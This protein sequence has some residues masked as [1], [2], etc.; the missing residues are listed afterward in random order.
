MAAP[1]Q[2][3]WAL[4]PHTAAKHA[5]LSR[6]LAAWLPI[7]SQGGFPKLAYIDAFSGPGRYSG[8]EDGSPVIALK[9]MLGHK[10]SITAQCYFDFVERAADRAAALRSAVEQTQAELGK[11]S[12]AHIEVHQST[13]ESAYEKIGPRLR[14]SG[15]IPTFAFIDPFGWTGLPFSIV[16]ELLNRPSTEV[17][18]NF[19]FEEINRFL[20]H[21]DQTENFDQLFGCADWRDCINLSGPERNQAL[22]DLYARK[23]GEN[24]K[25]VRYFEMRNKSNATDY[26]LFF[27]TNSLQGLKKMKEAMWKVDQGGAFN[28]SDA[29]NPNQMTLFANE[30]QFDQLKRQIMGQ[31][32]GM[33][34][35]IEQVEEFVLTRTAFRE[36]HFKRQ[37]LAKVE[38]QDFEVAQSKPG[39]RRGT[40]PAGTLLKFFG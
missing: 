38:G 22:R 9:A 2:T 37:V 32:R 25:Y 39:R 26:F 14:A 20:D 36:A 11:P 7:V 21:R 30:P 19:M 15:T 35:S 13:F 8:G 12:N 10:A 29:T 31:F 28:F 34:V 6:Y 5:I 4:E 18:V 3:V 33:R 24:A 1:K 27:A 23:L 40:Y 16:R 17:L